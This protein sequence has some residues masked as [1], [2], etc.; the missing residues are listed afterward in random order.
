MTEQRTDMLRPRRAGTFLALSLSALSPLVPRPALSAFNEVRPSAPASR[1][2]DT[3]PRDRRWA[4][5]QLP[6]SRVV[7][8]KFHG[9]FRFQRLS[10][11]KPRWIRF[12]VKPGETLA[13]VAR[14]FGVRRAAIERWN[15]ARLHH[16]LKA[17]TKLRIHA[18]KFPPHRTRTHYW[19]DPN[20]SWASVARSYG[21][22]K[23]ELKRFNPDL[24]DRKLHR[25]DR[26]QVWADSPMPRWGKLEQQS[27]K[28]VRV[29]VPA[30]AVSLGHPA[31]GRIRHARRLPR[32]PLYSLIRPQW[33]YAGTNTMAQLQ[34]GIATWRRRTGFKGE[35]VISSLS[36]RHGGRFRPHRSHQSGR[37]VD[38][39]LVAFP[40]FR[41]GKKPH[42]AE[43]D[44]G[45]TWTLIR[46]FIRSGEVEHIFL[47]RPLQKKLYDAARSMG[48]SDRA[49]RRLFQ[50]P[51]QGNVPRG[52]IRHEAGHRRHFHV[53]WSCGPRENRC[54]GTRG[55]AVLGK[56]S[57]SYGL[58]GA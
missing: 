52:I 21:L 29:V 10:R 33:A 43:V 31:R 56:R 2:T 46:E 5:G 26:V 19:V 57:L 51:R 58:T 50:Y 22:S 30:G 38:I 7:G 1:D 27:R 3:Q 16:G 39:A 49:L 17:G 8:G 44:W 32:S 13:Q 42:H 45:A 11:P 18:R 40:G 53:R 25:G 14:R 20:E 23:R 9:V 41:H 34:R 55:T 24:R 12:D 15:R 36:K 6:G 28:P 47:N 54:R 37:D 35:V 4:E 48:E